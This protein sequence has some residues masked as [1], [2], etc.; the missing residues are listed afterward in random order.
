LPASLS[1]QPQQEASA[2]CAVF[3]PQVSGDTLRYWIEIHHFT[4]VVKKNYE[5]NL[6]DLPLF[7]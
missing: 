1:R 3:I 6:L 2:P 5:N 7:P 4:S